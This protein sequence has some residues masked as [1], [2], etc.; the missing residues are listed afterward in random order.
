MKVSIRQS[1]FETNSSSV[2]SCSICTDTDYNKWKKGELWYNEGEDKYI[3]KNEAIEFN[4]NYVK[5]NDEM[6]DEEFEKFAEI[7]RNT[8]EFN[9]AYEAIG[10]EGDYN[11]FDPYDIYMDIDKYWEYHEYEDWTH[12]F[13]DTAGVKMVAWGYCGHD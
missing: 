3:Q 13:K 7:Y 6:T 4:L 5:E 2:H 10:W 8:G 1:V 12:V 11:D 9:K